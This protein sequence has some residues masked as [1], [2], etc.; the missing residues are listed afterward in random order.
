MDG[1]IRDRVKQISQACRGMEPGDAAA[2]L[3]A[4]ARERATRQDPTVSLHRN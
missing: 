1:V 4:D 2:R 3:T